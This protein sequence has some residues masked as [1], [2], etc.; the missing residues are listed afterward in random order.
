MPRPSRV[1]QRARE[2]ALDA[3]ADGATAPEIGAELGI[4]AR[5]VLKIVSAARKQGDA[6]AVVRNPGAS[7]RPAPVA[8]ASSG[9][10]LA[11]ARR[12]I[13]ERRAAWERS[14]LGRR[15]AAIAVPPPAEGDDAVAL[16]GLLG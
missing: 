14:E 8:Y 1:T 2:S 6:R 12:R 13:E 7:W 4:S 15:M 3:W 5:S 16:E 11:D 10:F 9:A